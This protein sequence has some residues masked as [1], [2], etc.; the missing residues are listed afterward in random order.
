MKFSFLLILFFFYLSTPIQAKTK[1]SSPVKIQQAQL[2][3]K[4]AL[5]NYRLETMQIKVKQEI[6]LSFIKI[7]MKSQGI[8]NIKDEKFYLNLKG[9]PSSIILFDGDFLWYQA[10]QK[11]KT[12]FK[13]KDHPQIQFL[14][15]LFSEKLF[16][17]HFY[18]KQALKSNQNYILQLLPKTKIGGL[19]E[20]FLKVD[21]HILELRLIWKD[22]NNWQ[23]YQFSKPI[24]KEFSDKSFQFHS[25]GFQVIT[26]KAFF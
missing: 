15:V 19:K 1:A 13:L 7:N 23:K 17:K 3:L 5:K 12:V 26:K 22:L 11:E 20:M 10:D 4:K 25:K 14:A 16:F 9:Q 24:Y 18:I 2:I 8:L 6:F 21:S